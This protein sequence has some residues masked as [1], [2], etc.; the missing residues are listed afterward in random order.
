MPEKKWPSG[1]VEE[2]LVQMRESG[3]TLQEIAQ[4]A[5]VHLSTAAIHLNGIIPLSRMIQQLPRYPEKWLHIRGEC[6]WTADWHAPYFSM[7]WL[8]R[9]IVVCQKLGI[10]QLAIVGDLTDL[11]WISRFA[12]R[13]LS[14]S[15][16]EEMRIVVSLLQVLLR[17]FDRVYWIWGNHEDRLL[18]ALKGQDLLPVMADLIS[19]GETGDL[20]TSNAGTILVDDDWRLVHPS[21]YSRDAAK[22]AVQIAAITHKNIACGHGHFIGYKHDVSGKYIGIDLGGMFD[23]EK[24][25]YL[26]MGGPTTHPRWNPGFWVYHNGR[27][28][29]FDDALVNWDEW[30]INNDKL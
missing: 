6:A 22:T 23:I 7:M 2:K 1:E 18:V 26:H 10:P 12:H 13:D 29:P 24:Q 15:L 14:G 27:P 16:D 11:K 19:E 25:E 30:D 17:C 20:Y 4:Q 5:G 3:A 28:E 9:L 8:K 21:T